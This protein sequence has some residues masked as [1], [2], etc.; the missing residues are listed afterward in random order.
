MHRTQYLNSRGPGS[1]GVRAGGLKAVTQKPPHAV[2][3]REGS[4]LSPGSCV[5]DAG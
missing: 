1:C 5:C 2:P 4:S 3:F